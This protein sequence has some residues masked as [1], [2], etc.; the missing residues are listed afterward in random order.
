LNEAQDA[1]SDIVWS[2]TPRHDTLEDLLWRM[3]DLASDICSSNGI[4]YS[5][6]I[7]KDPD[8]IILPEQL[9]KSIYLIF[10]ESINNFVKHAQASSA[11]MRVEVSNGV[12]DMVIEDDGVGFACDS[13]QAGTADASAVDDH[14]VRGHGLRNMRKRAEDIGG[15]L[16]IQSTP[17]K[18]TTLRLS[19]SM[20]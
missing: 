20:T 19:V 4:A 3:K 15:T 1:V 18:G 13:G 2:V 12:F 7:P 5:V 14:P 8:V 16:S 17:G 11:T 6:H 10:K 9:R